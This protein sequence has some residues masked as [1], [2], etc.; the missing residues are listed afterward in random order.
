M[1]K[2]LLEQAQRF[3]EPQGGGWVQLHTELRHDEIAAIVSATRVSVT[4]AFMELRGEGV[5]EGSRGNYR[6][7]VSALESFVEA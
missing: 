3:G 2:T 1:V 4:T 6:L 7:N 5:L